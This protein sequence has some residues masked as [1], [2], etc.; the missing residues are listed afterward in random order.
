MELESL[1]QSEK[2]QNSQ[3]KKRIQAL[4]EELDTTIQSINRDYTKRITDAI[5][6]TQNTRVYKVG[7]LVR[8]FV[9]QCFKTGEMYDFF[10]YLYVN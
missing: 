6:I 9:I 7:L 5:I 2:A 3:L 4:S 1:L 10:K 8:R